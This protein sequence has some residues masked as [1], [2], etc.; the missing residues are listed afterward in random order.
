MKLLFILL[1]TSNLFSNCSKDKVEKVDN[2]DTP[3]KKGFITG[4]ILDPQGK[5]LAGARVTASHSTWYNTT[6]SGVTN[7]K[8]IYTLDMNGQPGGNWS[9]MAKYT[10]P[11]PY[12]GKTYVFELRSEDATPVTTPTEGIVR[13]MSWKLSGVVPGSTTDARIGTYLTYFSG[14][15]VPDEELEFTLEPVGPLVDG[16]TGKTIV[17]RASSFPS[18]FIGMYSNIGVRDIPTG[19]YKVSVHHVPPAGS[20][21]KTI[22]LSVRGKGDYQNSVTVDPSQDPVYTN[23]TE[24]ELDLTEG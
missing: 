11:T 7:D 22:K 5:P 12:N 8:G 9:L 19:R 15:D 21:V 3:A 24:L 13:N 2:G 16:S 6:I 14:V 20:P 1:L 10:T 18:S 4:K 23:Y 17:A